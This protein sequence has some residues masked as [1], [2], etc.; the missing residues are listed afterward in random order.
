MHLRIATLAALALGGSLAAQTTL[1]QVSFGAADITTLDLHAYTETQGSMTSIMVHVE[2]IPGSPVNLF[3]MPAG[4]TLAGPMALFGVGQLDGTG[5]TTF[6]FPIPSSV[7]ETFPNVDIDFVAATHDLN[8]QVVAT[9]IDTLRLGVLPCE[10]LD[11]DFDAEGNALEAGEQL[12]AQY[13]SIGLNISADN[14]NPTHPDKA[15]L[16]DSGNPTGE[17]DDLMTPGP[18]PNNNTPLGLLMIVA[19]DDVDLDMNGLVDDPDDEADGGI[20]TFQFD[21][22]VSFCDIT[23]VDLDDGGGSELRFYLSNV[24]VDTVPLTPGVENEV[25]TI[26]ALV[27]QFDRMEVDFV[28]S[29]A[30]SNFGFFF[31]PSRVD[32]DTFTTG[33]PTGLVAGENVTNQYG[34]LGLF[35]AAMNNTL[36][37]PDKAI[38][39]DTANVTGEDTDLATPGP[40]I[41]NNTALG[42]VLIIAEDDVDDDMDGNVDDP[43]DEQYGGTMSFSFVSDILFQSATL[44]DIDEDETGALE[45]YDGDDM[46]ITFLPLASLGDNSVQ[47]VAEEIGGVRRIDVVL[48]GSGALAELNFCPDFGTPGL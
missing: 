13:A 4:S 26:G 36:G 39:F 31:C 32:F 43:D 44:L 12:L 23:L 37:N 8:A 16:F 40:G 38:V 14:K 21:D 47:T 15:I 34:S 28:G 2:G 24:L 20:I 35:I 42:M 7:Y 33:L 1:S 25:L 46:F 11:F 9:P 5:Q 29:G 18:G 41:N 3:A 19:E 10:Q 45:F 6:A 48:S 17:D 22:P 27:Q 30:V